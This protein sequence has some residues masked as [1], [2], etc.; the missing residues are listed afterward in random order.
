MWRFG[1]FLRS[2]L[3]VFTPNKQCSC[4]MLRSIS[5]HLRMK[6]ANRAGQ[7]NSLSFSRKAALHGIFLCFGKRKSQLKNILKR[8]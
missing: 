2:F 3:L 5:V 6:R 7:A 1:L 8:R 4:V